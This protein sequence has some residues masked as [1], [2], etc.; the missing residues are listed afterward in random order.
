MSCNAPDKDGSRDKRKPK[1]RSHHDQ[2]ESRI[3]GASLKKLYDNA[4]DEP[5]SQEFK[6]LLDKLK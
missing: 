3:F 5:L 2:P 4:L 6:D 1:A